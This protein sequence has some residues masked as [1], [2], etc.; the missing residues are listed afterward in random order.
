[1]ILNKKYKEAMNHIEV[2]EEMRQR[3]M[4]RVREE[5]E[6]EKK[7]RISIFSFQ[8]QILTL[9]TCLLLVIGIHLVSKIGDHA[10][11][12]VVDGN[13]IVSA[14]SIEE[15]SEIVGFHVKE[16][17]EIPF[18]VEEISYIA[19][20]SDMAETIYSSET[21][22]VTFRMSK[23]QE[24]NSGDYNSYT[25]ETEMKY[26]NQEIILKGMDAHYTLAIWHDSTYSYS[27]SLT[28]GTS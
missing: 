9:A 24:D 28:E 13:Q 16:L 26:N 1:M 10:N 15:L 27:I 2:D 25:H 4:S 3:I 14:S 23:G 11:Q 6:T 7:F 18:D 20:G 17:E 22:S 12:P 19:Y 5:N 21:Q 8:K